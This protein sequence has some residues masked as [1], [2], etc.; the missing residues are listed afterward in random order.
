VV[1]SVKLC[2]QNKG[3]SD[4]IVVSPAY[5]TVAQLS[6]GKI[7]NG[8]LLMFQARKYNKSKI[9]KVKSTATGEV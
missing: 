7:D 6:I 9:I 4:H 3:A 1:A 8:I 5:T 2:W